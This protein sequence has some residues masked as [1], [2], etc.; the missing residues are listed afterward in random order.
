MYATPRN[1]RRMTMGGDVPSAQ[2]TAGRRM[3]IDPSSSSGIPR[4]AG[5]PGRPPK[6]RKSM[7]PRVG[8]ENAPPPPS[9]A[10]SVS[11]VSS[12]SSVTKSTASSRR[13]SM[14]GKDKSR[15]QSL[16]PPPSQSKPSDPR[17]VNDKAFQHQCIK[18]LLA[19]LHESGYEYPLSHKSLSR[20]SAKDFTNITTFMLR[21][22][23][24]TFQ[25]GSMKFE[26]EVALNF[27]CL[28]Y[29][30]TI[31]KTA[32]VA[33]GSLHTWPALLAA[34]TWL[35]EQI[36]ICGADTTT[37]EEA[38]LLQA[39]TEEDTTPFDS[40]QELELKTDKAFFL[41]LGQAYV[42]FMRGD[43]AMTERLESALADRFE[44]DDAVLEQAVERITDLNATILEKINTLSQESQ[45]YVSSNA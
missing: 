19:F 15:R 13:R 6:G 16:V 32:L 33:A 27:K 29:P 40:L 17:P 21:R 20:P 12:V 7:L 10:N 8:R 9:P 31:S 37:E 24:P 45:E 34:L 41:Y 4:P 28:G 5:G 22:I 36:Q 30:Y 38:A 3:S 39:G 44:R 43:G 14:G 25:T 23:D 2:K 18:Q 1:R 42:A 26:D 35:M 11:S